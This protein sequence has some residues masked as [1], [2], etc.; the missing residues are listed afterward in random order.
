MGAGGVGGA[1]GVERGR[2]CPTGAYP[3]PAAELTGS[4][5]DGGQVTQV[6]LNGGHLGGGVG[7]QDEVPRGFALLLVAAGDA[8]VNA[9]ILL[10]QPPAQRQPHTAVTGRCQREPNPA[11]PR[12][13]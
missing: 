1:R 6:H 12:P 8:E 2:G 7:G 13:G 10:Q 11:Q 9:A 4:P 5:Q 3:I